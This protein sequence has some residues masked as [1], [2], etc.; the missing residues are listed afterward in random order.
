MPRASVNSLPELE[1]RIFVGYA[2]GQ[3][4]EV[5]LFLH[6]N[7]DSRLASL[8][9]KVDASFAEF[10]RRVIALE[11]AQTDNTLRWMAGTLA[12]VKAFADDHAERLQ[13]ID[14]PLDRI[15][16]DVKGLRRDMPGIVAEALRAATHR[17]RLQ[18]C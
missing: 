2:Q 11:K 16:D 6:D 15:E 3:L 1:A 4:R 7:I 10:E 8:E 5:Q 18:S 14:G 9:V 12:Q 17:V 13:R